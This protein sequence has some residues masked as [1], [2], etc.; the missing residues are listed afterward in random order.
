MLH[1]FQEHVW[2]HQLNFIRKLS[3]LLHFTLRKTKMSWK[4]STYA[5]FWKWKYSIDP[6]WFN[7]NSYWLQIFP[8]FL[9]NLNLDKSSE[10]LRHLLLSANQSF[11]MLLQFLATTF[12]N[13][14]IVSI[15]ICLWFMFFYKK[16]HI[17]SFYTV[18]KHFV[19]CNNYG[20]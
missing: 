12:F 8:I 11:F 5:C 2:K 19:C 17:T 16:H 4:S 3:N 6:L 15:I 18:W 1:Y 7:Y 10:A 14:Y 9:S 13:C 20:I